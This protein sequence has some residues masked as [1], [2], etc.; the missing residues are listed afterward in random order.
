MTCRLH[1]LTGTQRPLSAFRV[2]RV[3]ARVHLCTSFFQIVSVIDPV[4]IR[5]AFFLR[6]LYAVFE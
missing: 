4:A 3:S 6:L 1:V 2:L 5:Y